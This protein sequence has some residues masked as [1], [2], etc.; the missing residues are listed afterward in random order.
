MLERRHF[1]GFTPSVKLQDHPVLMGFYSTRLI[2]KF[3]D[4]SRPKAGGDAFAMPSIISNKPP[5]LRDY[6]KGNERG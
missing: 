3:H 2:S 4:K 5:L 6:G 1:D